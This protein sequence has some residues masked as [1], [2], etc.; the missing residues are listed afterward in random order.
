[1]N[2]PFIHT[3][4]SV[5]ESTILGPRVKIWDQVQIREFVNIGEGTIIGRAAYI[6][7][8]VTIGKNCK[9]QN[10]AQV[11]S[12]ATIHDG[13]FL[14]P[15]VIL[16]N[17]L[18]PRAVTSEGKL[19]SSSDWTA[20]GVEIFDGAS[21]GAGA[22][23]VAPVK[24]GTWAMIGAGSVVTSDIPNFALYIGVPARQIG[25]VGREGHKLIPSTSQIGT[26]TC[27]VSGDTY[28]ETSGILKE[29]H[30]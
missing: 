29:T 18:N 1:M 5:H 25:W 19:K 9:I 23:C 4:A 3:T 10:A 14:G 11:Y 16:T 2:A 8:K 6:D 24:I 13:V 15:G 30:V 12:P 21:I 28:L 26:Y 22:I 17:D 7:T 20:T 27:P